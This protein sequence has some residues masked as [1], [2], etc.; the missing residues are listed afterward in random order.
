MLVVISLPFLSTPTTGTT[1]KTPMLYQRGKEPVRKYLGQN[2][3]MYFIFKAC[4]DKK[5]PKTGGE[6][7][8]CKKVENCNRKAFILACCG[9]CYKN[10]PNFLPKK[11]TT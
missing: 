3:L 7:P 9:S 2:F 5:N 11:K 4:V 1:P 6:L 10:N 8:G